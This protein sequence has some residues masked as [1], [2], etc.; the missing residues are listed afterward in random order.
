MVAEA[1]GGKAPKRHI[2]QA[3]VAGVKDAADADALLAEYKKAYPG[4]VSEEK[5]GAR[6]PKTV[7]VY[8]PNRV[9]R[10]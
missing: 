3:H 10:E 4:T 7:M 6:G 5:T 1:H 9:S 2:Q 8:A